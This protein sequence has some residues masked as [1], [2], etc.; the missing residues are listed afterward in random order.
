MSTRRMDSG[1]VAARRRMPVPA[2][3]TST[4]PSRP[5]THTQDVFPPYRAISGPGVASDPRVPHRVTC[6]SNFPENHLRAE[7]LAS[8]ADERKRRDV[9]VQP[10]SVPA[11]HPYRAGVGFA[12]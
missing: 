6:I 7:E 5:A 1:I 9:H 4:V 3:S 10:L 2:S 12:L 8:V 11:S